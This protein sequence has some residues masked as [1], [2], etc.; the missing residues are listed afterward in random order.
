VNVSQVVLAGLP[1]GVQTLARAACPL[2]WP[3]F[4][5]NGDLLAFL[6]H[7]EVFPLGEGF[8]AAYVVDLK[9]RIL[10]GDSLALGSG[11]VFSRTLLEAP[12]WYGPR[13]LRL[14]GKQVD[15]FGAETALEKSVAAPVK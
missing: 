9:G 11:R 13:E 6:A 4:S 15:V 3:V 14:K 10:L 12:V 2:S 1:E 7:G 5:P 8:C